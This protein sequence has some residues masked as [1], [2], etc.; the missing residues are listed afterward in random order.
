MSWNLANILLG[1]IILISLFYGWRRGIW[2]GLLDLIVWAGGLLL[3]LVLYRFLGDW[4]VVLGL[5]EVWAMPLAFLLLIVGVGLVFIGIGR[6]IIGRVPEETR[7]H[8]TTRAL[9]L[10]PGLGAGLL[11]ASLV[12]ALLLTVPIPG[13]LGEDVRDSRWVSGLAGYANRLETALTPV[14]GRAVAQTLAMITVQPASHEVIDLP[15]R[16][17]NVSPRPYLET[18]MLEL[19]NEERVQVGLPPLELDPELTMVARRHSVD[20]LARGYFAHVSPDGDDPF[21][22]MGEAGLT[23]LAAGENLAMAPSLP[24]AHNGLMNS[25]DHRANILREDFRRAGIGIIDGGALGLM[26]TQLFRD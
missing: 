16:E 22:R 21:D 18:R 17:T 5:S 23:Y 20:M 14:F 8:V 4:L 15:Y 2:V 19:V 9:G 1:I 10:L 24:L 11:M 6:T 26:V 3:A 12:S 13:K 25:P 7:E